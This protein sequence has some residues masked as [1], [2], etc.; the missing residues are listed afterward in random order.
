MLYYDQANTP[1][2]PHNA[3]AHTVQKLESASMTAYYRLARTVRI[4]PQENGGLALCSYPL[5]VLRLSTLTTRLLLQCREQR[6]CEEL[7]QLVDL[8]TKRVQTLCEQLRWKELLEAGPTL[9]PT[10]WPA[11]SII[12]P[13]HNRVHQLER[14]LKSLL[15]LDYPAQC[16]ELIVVDDASTDQTATMLQ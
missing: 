8:P 2:L 12:V 13:S 9:P 15:S 3:Q 6:T 16:L 7:A 4:I 11:V 14:C 1:R 5:R 10:T